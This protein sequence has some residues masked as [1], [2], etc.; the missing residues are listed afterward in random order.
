M[1]MMI[2]SS[3]TVVDGVGPKYPS[4]ENLYKGYFHH[5][6]PSSAAGSKPGKMSR[7]KINTD[8]IDARIRS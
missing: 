5:H 1:S 6:Q 3:S 8:I 2:R 4:S 7:S